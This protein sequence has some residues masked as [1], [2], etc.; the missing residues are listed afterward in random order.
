MP[1]QKASESID[2]FKKRV[3]QRTWLWLRK[4]PL[5]AK[6][7]VAILAFAFIV[8]FSRMN[9]LG[10]PL[11]RLSTFIIPLQNPALFLTMDYSISDTYGIRTGKKN[12]LCHSGDYINLS[13]IPSDDCWSTLFCLDSKGIHPLFDNSLE[14]Q[15][16]K[17]GKSILIKFNLDTILG[18]EIYYAVATRKNF[19]FEK[20]IIPNLG[21]STIGIKGPDWGNYRLNLPKGFIQEYFSFK[22]EK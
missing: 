7:L 10:E 9:L 20:K 22:H 12:D 16:L 15:L 3:F 1:Q 11:Y 2:D 19:S 4:K 17:G 6:I 14:P 8:L 21:K 18:N 13:F 5:W